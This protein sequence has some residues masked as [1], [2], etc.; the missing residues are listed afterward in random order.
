MFLRQ[1]SDSLPFVTGRGLWTLT[2]TTV[3][4]ETGLR[5]K[6]M[7]DE[8]QTDNGSPILRDD[9]EANWVDDMD[10]WNRFFDESMLPVMVECHCGQEFEAVNDFDFECDFCRGE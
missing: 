2:G 5:V 6:Q 9:T 8:Y 1:R 3:N 10:R 7:D 4:G